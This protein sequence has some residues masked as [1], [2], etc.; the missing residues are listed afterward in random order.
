MPNGGQ[1][2]AGSGLRLQPTYPGATDVGNANIDG[3]FH[4]Q[5]V[6]TTPSA[7]DSVNT[8][9]EQFGHANTFQNAATING[10]AVFVF[11]A[12]NTVGHPIAT[13]PIM[14]RNCG[15]YGANCVAVG[16]A[17]VAG[18]VASL[19]SSCVAMGLNADANGQG[20]DGGGGPVAIGSSV[21]ANN[22]SVALGKSCT[23]TNDNVANSDCVAMG[24]SVSYTNAAAAS[25]VALGRGIAVTAVNC[26]VI[27]WYN[28]D[29][30]VTPANSIIIGRPDQNA[31]VQIG[32]FNFTNGGAA[33]QRA[34]ADANATITATDST[35]AYTSITA[36]RTVS[37][38]A[39]NAVPAGFR[40]LIVDES[41]NASAVNTITINRAGADTINGAASTVINAAYGCRELISDGGTKWT[42]IRSI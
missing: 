21:R 6:T 23:A 39:A 40:V 26:L 25:G 11:G 38:P 12:G 36:A 32:P 7:N 27:G 30:P 35:V 20:T 29:Q 42:I 5:R 33:T 22:G 28:A 14:G 24:S 18:N 31:K 13:G 9:G 1:I 41:G 17:A 37:L 15:I 2:S 19:P 34:I 8:S 16:V 4:A 3:V 10:Q